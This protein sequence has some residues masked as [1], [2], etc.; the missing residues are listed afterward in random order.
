MLENDHT[1]GKS[2]RR[3]FRL[4]DT[5]RIR[6]GVFAN[7]TGKIEGIN[8]SKML[9]KVRIAIFSRTTPVKLRFAEVDKIG[10]T[11]GE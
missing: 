8:Q 1:H 4:G 5:V 10:L 11:E 9:L 3:V 6:S 7:F 2:R